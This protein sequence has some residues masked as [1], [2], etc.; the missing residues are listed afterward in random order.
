MTDNADTIPLRGRN[1]GSPLLCGPH[2]KSSSVGEPAA[3]PSLSETLR[4]VRDVHKQLERCAKDVGQVERECDSAE[5]QS[6]RHPVAVSTI[7]IRLLAA[8]LSELLKLEHP[9]E[10]REYCPDLCQ[11][12]DCPRQP[13]L[14]QAVGHT[15]RVLR[16]TRGKFKSK[17]LAELRVSLETLLEN[18]EKSAR[19]R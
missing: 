11:L 19:T 1:S 18:S 12:L 16:Q 7:T 13:V 10:H 14:R 6:D 4:V 8:C 15:I 5:N 9:Q 17:E 2:S 3:A